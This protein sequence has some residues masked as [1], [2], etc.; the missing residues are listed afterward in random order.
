MKKKK[1]PMKKI[2]SASVGE[3]TE[4]HEDVIIDDALDQ[5]INDI[6]QGKE[7]LEKAINDD[8]LG[9]T[10]SILGR[11][12]RPITLS[13]I[14]LLQKTENELVSG[15][16]ISECKDIILDS[17]RFVVLQSTTLS[18][19]TKLAGDVDLLTTK[20]YELA[21]SIPLHQM[22]EFSDQ[23]IKV[24][25]DAQKSRVEPVVPDT[26]HSRKSVEATLGEA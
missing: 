11:K 17:C 22:D 8:L 14:I 7:S 13:S 16:P 18:E 5:T 2:E 4:I 25:S 19:A 1:T 20:A 24:I 12:V 15:K 9:I 26:S 10:P 21:D 3:T 23:V 6:E